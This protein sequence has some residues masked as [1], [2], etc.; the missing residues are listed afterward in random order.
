RPTLPTPVP[1]TT[2][3]RS[4]AELPEL[5]PR[6]RPVHVRRDE[7]RRL[8]LEFE[9][10]RQLRRGRG[11]PRALQTHEQDHGGAHGCEVE[12]LFRTA[13]HSGDFVVHQLHYL[14]AGADSLDLKRP[15]G[16]LSH[17]LDERASHLEAHIRLE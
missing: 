8:L 5:L 4:L 1:Y 2:L 15:H 6:R 9:P 17:P 10:P 7:T 16:A 3:F 14:L 12:P 13:Q 11:F